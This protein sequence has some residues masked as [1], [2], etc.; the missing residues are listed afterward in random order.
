MDRKEKIRKA[1]KQVSEKYDEALRALAD[2]ERLE[3]EGYSTVEAHEI[4]EKKYFKT[5]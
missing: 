4:V 2:V 1:A 5:K 3:R